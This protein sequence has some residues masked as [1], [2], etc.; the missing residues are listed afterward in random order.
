MYIYIYYLHIYILDKK[1]KI[2][3]KKSKIMEQ[4]NIF[5]QIVFPCIYIYK[6][7]EFMCNMKRK[8]QNYIDCSPILNTNGKDN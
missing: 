3:I 2:Y 6:L 8:I 4:K 1:Q 7:Q 5:R